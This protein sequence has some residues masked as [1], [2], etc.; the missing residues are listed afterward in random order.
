MLRPPWAGSP[1]IK[2]R[3]RDVT[4]DIDFARERV[5]PAD[6]AIGALAGPPVLLV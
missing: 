6:H 5:E 2:A 4:S 1:W 3:F